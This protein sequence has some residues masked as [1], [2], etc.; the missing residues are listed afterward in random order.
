MTSDALNA[1]TRQKDFFVGIDSDG[2]AFDSMEIKHKE[3][4]IPNFIN[5]WNLQA[6][7]SLARQTWEFVNLY[8]HWRGCNR[9]PALLLSLDLLGERPEAID[10]GFALPRIDSLRDWVKREKALGNPALSREVEAAGDAV[11]RQALDWSKGVNADVAKIVRNLPPFPQV[12]PCLEKL[13]PAA[14]IVVVSSTPGEALQREWAEHDIARF[15][16]LIAGQ[17]MGT[18][19]ELL[20]LCAADKYDADRVIMIGDAPGDLQAAKDNGALFFPICPA[21]ENDSWRRFH[22]EGIDRF[23]AG[24]FRGAYED[25]LIEEFTALLP[26]VP[27]WKKE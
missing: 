23:Q 9:F 2:C 22:D 3:C 27:P 11:L 17:E 18:K 13:L 20:R 1:F 8:S 14:D 6:V 10:R 7:S 16:R 15:T 5:H 4:F 26:T 19:K 24:T 12:K 25:R 21:R